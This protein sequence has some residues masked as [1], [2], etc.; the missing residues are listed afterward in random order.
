MY[1]IEM[2]KMSEEFLECWKAAGSHLH[3]QAREGNLTWLRAHPYPPYLE[4]LSFRV[5]N[6]LFFVRIEDAEG[7]VLGPG[8]L[9]GLQNVAEGNNGHA[10]IMPMK[11]KSSGE[12]WLPEAEGWGLIDASTGK[13]IDPV[14]LVTEEKIEMTPWEL[15]D[16][17]VQIVREHIEKKGYQ[18]MSWQG[19]P[20]M[21]PSI[22]FVGES[23]GP[24]WVVVRATSYPEAHAALPENWKE[25]VGQCISISETGH[26]ASVALA[27]TEQKFDSENEEAVPLYRDDSMYIQ[28]PGLEGLVAEEQ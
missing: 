23:N 18:L 17:A 9:E 4:H 2:E 10:C 1:D 22:W 12:E 7:G 26:F 8:T 5:G 20:E 13:T 21:D 24:E 3:S 25:I 19:H 15:H 6:Q 28:F 27:S 11:K 16:M 14:S